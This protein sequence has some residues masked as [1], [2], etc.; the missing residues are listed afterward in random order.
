MWVI[1]VSK[2]YKHR[3]RNIKHRDNTRKVWQIMYYEYDE[4]GELKLHQKY[5][6][7][8]QAIYYKFHKYYKRK[9]Y[10]TECEVFVEVLVKKNAKH[11]QC[12]FCLT[13]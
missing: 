3:G 1:S 10:C 2:T 12:P 8:L 13:E 9:F 11:V 4:E 5:V 6:N 7:V